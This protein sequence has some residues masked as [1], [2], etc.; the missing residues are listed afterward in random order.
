MKIDPKR[1]AFQHHTMLVHHAIKRDVHA[2]QAEKLTEMFVGA[3]YHG[4]RGI[5]R[6]RRLFETDFAPVTNAQS[7]EMPL[8]RKFEQLEPHIADCIGKLNLD[9]TVRIVNGDNKDDT[10]NFEQGPVWSILVGGAKLSRGYT[11]EGLTTTYFRRVSKASD[12]LM[13][14]G[15]WFGFRPGYRDLVRLFIGREEP[16][17]QKKDTP[18]DLYEAFRA[19]CLDEEE[20]R[21]DIQKYL[22]EDIRPIQ[23]PPLVPSHLESLMPTAR[24]KMYNARITFKNVG[25]AFVERT[26]SPATK[27]AAD[28]NAE[29]SLVLLS[30]AKLSAT[31]LA[32]GTGPSGLRDFDAYVG[33]VSPGEMLS[34]LRKYRWEQDKGVLRHEIEYL[35]GNGGD[36]EIGDW[37]I[38]APQLK[39]EGTEW[40]EQKISNVPKLSVKKRSRV[41]TRFGVFSEPLHVEASKYIA[42]LQP[43][44]VSVSSS[45][46]KLRKV[47]RAVMLF[48]PVKASGDPF[49]TIGFALQLP[50]NH[51]KR[52]LAY[53]VIRK[54]EEGAPEPVVVDLP[55]HG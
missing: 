31:N 3:G 44:E 37:L 2:D 19:I 26:V 5:E 48:Y 49:I 55:P 52:R 6:L 23:V 30:A 15:R 11:V 47:G 17:G 34:F 9:K 35:E 33:A 51:L 39:G 42:G 53:E 54:G 43:S 10:P 18:L 12:T 14:M 16:V 22:V 21:S 38:V 7:Q 41:G 45:L 40:P 13:Q 36:P 25:G 32:I 8:P 46:E 27:S 20:F 28:D 29:K 4:G 50:M 1:F 24:N